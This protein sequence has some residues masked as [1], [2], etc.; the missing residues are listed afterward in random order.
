[1]KPEAIDSATSKKQRDALIESPALPVPFHICISEAVVATQSNRS[2]KLVWVT[3]MNIPHFTTIK[4]DTRIREH[5]RHSFF[6]PSKSHCKP[7]FVL[8]FWPVCFGEK[9]IQ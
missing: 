1:M 8:G 2:E 9:I 7:P 5:L 3:Q 6:N 4:N